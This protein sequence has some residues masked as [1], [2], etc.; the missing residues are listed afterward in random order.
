MT[1]GL[2]VMLVGALSVG[3]FFRYQL[4]NGLRLLNGDRY[5]G[6]IE[7]SILEH[8]H[9][10][11]QGRAHW[12]T[13]NYFFPAPRTLGYND[14]YLLFGSIHSAFRH[15]G[16]DPFLS[17][18]LV[19]VTLRGIGFAAFYVA[20]RTI[21]QLP[22]C[23]SLFASALFTIANNMFMHGYHAQLFAVAFAPVMALLLHRCAEAFWS[24][25]PWRLAAW[26]IAAVGFYAAWLL[27]AYYTAWF[28][29]YF[30]SAACVVYALNSKGAH[31]REIL[32]R[33]KD[34]IPQLGVIAVAGIVLLAPFVW[35]YLPKA[36]ETGMHAFSVALAFAPNLLDVVNVGDGNVV[37]GR[38]VA[39]V[40]RNFPTTGFSPEEAG[41]GVPPLLL[42][43]FL[44][45]TAWLYR[46]QRGGD[47]DR[48]SLPYVIAVAALVTWILCIRIG[49][50]TA[51]SAVYH[52]VP[53]AKAVR[54]VTRYQIFLVAPV[55]LVAVWYLARARFGGVPLAF[56][57][58]A[59][60]LVEEANTLPPIGVER[61][62]EVERLKRIGVPPSQ[63]GAFF[64]TS[65]RDGGLYDPEVDAKYSHN[66]DAM[67]V[68]ET[69]NTPTINGFASFAP[70]GWSL[71]S[72]AAPD[73]R[74][75]V[76]AYAARN[77]VQRLCELNL[78]TLEW[79]VNPDLP[80]L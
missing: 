18:E 56:A 62:Q 66:V 48:P 1:R 46:D 26:G 59:A 33:A 22:L 65:A 76:A 12:A 29:A 6:V 49:P 30:A 14:G 13:T 32:A 68:A 78:R 60:L 4:S 3:F 41:T 80:A 21:L 74:E 16:L 19:N 15:L 40:K 55:V 67:M 58:C 9:N 43:T 69:T 34:R 23:W 61:P 47:R 42:G 53:G 72:P 24:P 57:F 38:L 52:L 17:S 54:A 25:R 31:L 63:C 71:F 75:R 39:A 28:F 45:A 44:V 79:T 77:G 73:Y 7:T 35:L 20:A 36:R 27:T 70:P 51:W 5:D 10:V 50:F 11:L 8:W 37:W 64:V 2:A